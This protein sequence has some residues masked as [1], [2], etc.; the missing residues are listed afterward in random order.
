VKGSVLSESQRKTP[1]I[2]WDVIVHSC[3]G[4]LCLVLG[5]FMFFDGFSWAVHGFS[6][7]MS[8]S[9]GSALLISVLTHSWVRGHFLAMFPVIGVALGY[10]GYEWG[11][12]LAYVLIWIAFLHFVWRGYQ[13]GAA[14]T[15]EPG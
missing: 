11:F 1:T 15:T 3:A 7:M 8:L 2:G 9:F 5:A 12:S 10:W 6:A 14:S 4:V 13:Q